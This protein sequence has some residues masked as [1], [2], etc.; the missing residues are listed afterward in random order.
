MASGAAAVLAELSIVCRSVS[1]AC[2][3]KSSDHF[4]APPLPVARPRR[5][6]PQTHRH[7]WPL[8]VGLHLGNQGWRQRHGRIG[9][10]V[11]S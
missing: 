8:A 5:V 7:R 2:L 10:R 3:K 1:K 9:L 11:L 6:V 4:C